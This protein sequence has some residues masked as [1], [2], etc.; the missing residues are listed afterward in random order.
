MQ[1][2][3]GASC[4][5]LK[6]KQRVQ[7]LQGDYMVSCSMD[8]TAK[9]WDLNTTKCKFTLRGHT[10]AVNNIVFKPFSNTVATC[11][12]DKN[13]MLWDVRL[14]LCRE[15]LKGHRSSINNV[16]YNFQGSTPALSWMQTC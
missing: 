13:I 16:A 15:K 1:D 10:D 11:S 14:G 6:L 9:L 2:A 8:H 5:P 4:I 12:G 3:E 7:L